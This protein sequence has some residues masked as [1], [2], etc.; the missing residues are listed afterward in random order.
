MKLFNN[1]YYKV[2]AQRDSK[3]FDECTGTMEDKKAPASWTAKTRIIGDTLKVPKPWATQ[4]QIGHLRWNQIY[5][6]GPTCV[7][8]TF[9]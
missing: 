8:N 3:V 6:R 4:D 7:K 2:M 1:K 5:E 9:G